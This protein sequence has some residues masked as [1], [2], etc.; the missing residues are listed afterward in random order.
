[1]PAFIEKLFSSVEIEHG[2]FASAEPTTRHIA[3]IKTAMRRLL[4]DG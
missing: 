3:A 1:V 2:D 4:V